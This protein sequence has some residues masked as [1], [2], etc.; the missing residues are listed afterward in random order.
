MSNSHL[1]FFFLKKK[2]EREERNNLASW[3]NPTWR[4][5]LY[6]D[7]RRHKFKF[8]YFWLQII[9]WL[10]WQLIPCKERKFVLK[11]MHIQ[12]CLVNWNLVKKLSRDAA[13]SLH[14]FFQHS[15]FFSIMIIWKVSKDFIDKMLTI[16]I[17]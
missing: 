17:Y 2:T 3:K 1:K 9:K 5:L 14:L 4:R 13:T 12:M 8:S 7:I 11:E 15:V 16:V 10:P 6:Y